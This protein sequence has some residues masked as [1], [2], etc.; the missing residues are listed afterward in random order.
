MRRFLIIFLFLLVSPT[1]LFAKKGF[2]KGARL[3]I[4]TTGYSQYD[5]VCQI[6][7]TLGSA[8]VV[9]LLESGVDI[10]NYQPTVSDITKILSCDMF[11]YT[12]GESD[13]W[14]ESILSNDKSNKKRQVI[15]IMELL[16]DYIKEEEIKEGMTVDEDEPNNSEDKEYDEHVWLSLK[17]AQIVIN[18]ITNRLI[19]LDPTNAQ[20]YEIHSQ[21]F[22]DKL[23]EL[24]TNFSQ[25]QNT[26]K[27]LI[28][29]DRFPFRYLFDD[30]N[31]KYYSAFPG[32]SSESEASFQTVI[33]LANKV[34]ELE[35]DTIFKIEGTL[36]NVANTVK[37]STKDKNQNIVILD[38]IQSVSKNKHNKGYSYYAAMEDNYTKISEYLS[39]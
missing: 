25:L 19:S 7:G 5:W 34:D 33:F 22:I 26:S 3:K 10:H 21:M 11:I 2:I 24:D 27:P 37:R 35:L 32:C 13:K 16:H 18:E 38:S 28:F 4:V 14:V 15:N 29:A 8:D 1:F 23:K 20:Y 36:D 12:G 30:Y 6:V 17:N 9:Y 31:M 39:K